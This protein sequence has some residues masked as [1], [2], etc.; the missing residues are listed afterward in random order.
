MRKYL[1]PVVLMGWTML[2][3]AQLPTIT[4]KTKGL[5]PGSGF[6]TYY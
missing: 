6:F 1:L 3:H 4:E 2:L 5:Q